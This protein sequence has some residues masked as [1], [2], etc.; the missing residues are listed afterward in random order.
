MTKSYDEEKFRESQKAVLVF[1][2]VLQFQAHVLSCMKSVSGARLLA[3][4][5]AGFL[6]VVDSF[7]QFIVDV[8]L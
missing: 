3:G 7:V 5:V 2:I 4:S 8:V 1:V 6:T